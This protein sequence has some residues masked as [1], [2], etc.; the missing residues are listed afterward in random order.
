MGQLLEQ[1][2]LLREH[3]LAEV[4][5]AL[6]DPPQRLVRALVGLLTVRFIVHVSASKND[7]EFSYAADDLPPGIRHKK[8]DM[9]GR[10]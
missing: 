9:S 2:L 7:D 6:D 3:L 1:F 5:E 4:P 8:S 10:T